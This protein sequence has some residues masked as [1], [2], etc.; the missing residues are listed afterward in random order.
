MLWPPLN[1]TA[2]G[3]SSHVVRSF[4]GP[5]DVDRDTARQP[6]LRL[7]ASLLAK[8][9]KRADFRSPG[10]RGAPGGGVA[11]E[12]DELG[13]YTEASAPFPSQRLRKSRRDTADLRSID[14]TNVCDPYIRTRR[15]RHAGAL[16]LWN[17]M[18][19]GPA[20]AKPARGGRPSVS[21][22]IGRR[23]RLDPRGRPSEAESRPP[24]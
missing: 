19:A 7:L 20:A 12:K 2:V 15:K 9:G 3:H 6:A 18:K 24:V 5:R 8:L 21:N 4:D 17:A 14:L 11:V 22:S 10:N 16:P 1:A 13:N 23:A